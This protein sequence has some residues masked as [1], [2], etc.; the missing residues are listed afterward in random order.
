MLRYQSDSDADAT[1]ANPEKSTDASFHRGGLLAFAGRL[2]LDRLAYRLWRYNPRGLYR[3]YQHHRF[4][5]I[6]RV[7]TRGYRD[8]RYEPTPA[9][10]L[11]EVVNSLQELEVALDRYVFVDIGSGKG[12]VLLLAS[13]YPF[14]KIVGVERWEDLH[15]VAV[16]NL[17]SFSYENSQCRQLSAVCID[18]SDFPLPS[19]PT[20]LYFFNPF[21]EAVLA[22]VLEKIERSLRDHRRDLLVVY[23]APILRRGTPWDRRRLFDASTYLEAV[24]CEKH[25][26]IYRSAKISRTF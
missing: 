12:K 17:Q 24:R 14:K 11:D 23:Y 19:D 6:H 15:Q 16:A 10:V 5:R 21:P 9:P 13:A 7:N 26:T 4:D 1:T 22:K 2:K 18:A 20:I 8:L 25:Y 3:L